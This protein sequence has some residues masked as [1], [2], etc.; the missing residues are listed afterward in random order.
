[1]SNNIVVNIGDLKDD[2]KFLDPVYFSVFNKRQFGSQLSKLIKKYKTEID[3]LKMESILSTERPD[4][5]V[6]DSKFPVGNNNFIKLFLFLNESIRLEQPY[7]KF[8]KK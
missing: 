5:G 2:C 4:W 8:N 3:M 7:I 6:L 1:M